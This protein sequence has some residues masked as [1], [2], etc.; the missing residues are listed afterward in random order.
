VDEFLDDAW[1]GTATELCDAL[2]AV[3]PE[4]DVAPRTITKRLKN[5]IGLFGKNNIAIAID[6]NRDS[7][8]ITLTRQGGEQEQT[9]STERDVVTT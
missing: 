2:K 9:D 6:R 5:N 4:A 1:S 8:A 7:R 3:D